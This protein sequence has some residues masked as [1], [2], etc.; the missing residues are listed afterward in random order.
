MVASRLR[1]C[2]EAKGLLTEEQR[3]S[4]LDRLT[5]DI[6]FVVRRLQEIAWELDLSIFMCSI[7][8]QKAY[9]TVDRALLWQVLP[10]N[11][12]PAQMIAAIR[13][14]HDGM[15]TRVRPG[16]GVCSNWFQVE[17]G[18]RQR[19]VLSPLSFNIFFAD[20]L[21]VVS[22]RFNKNTVI[23]TELVHLKEQPTPM[24]LE[25]TMDNVRR[26]V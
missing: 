11:G 14:F 15:G 17:Q 16:D 13:H 21:T 20:V 7:D 9:D 10:H 25:S 8:L 22:Q 24:R 12:V 19:C 6:M 23:L 2:C 4:R 1:H 18:L 3:E 26:A 5:T